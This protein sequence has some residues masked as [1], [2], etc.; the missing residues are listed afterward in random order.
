MVDLVLHFLTSV[1]AVGHEG[2]WVAGGGGCT[3]C[4]AGTFKN[5]AGDGVCTGCLAGQQANAAGTGCEDCPPDTYSANFGDPCTACDAN[6]ET[7]DSASG[8]IA[9]GKRN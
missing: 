3:A 2:T 5:T 8:A 9:C 4:V 7:T 6:T 1:C